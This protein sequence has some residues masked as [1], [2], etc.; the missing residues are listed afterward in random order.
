[1]FIFRSKYWES[2]DL[3]EIQSKIIMYKEVEERMADPEDG[4][5]WYIFWSD[6]TLQMY[7]HFVHN[8]QSI[9][10]QKLME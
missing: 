5:S 8:S 4:S 7:L 2:H 1:M 9:L 6:R 3:W 10:N